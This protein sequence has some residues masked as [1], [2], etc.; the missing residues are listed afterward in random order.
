MSFWVTFALNC[1]E[2]EQ[3][4]SVVFARVPQK[5]IHSSVRV[6]EGGLA[7]TYLD[8]LAGQLRGSP[9]KTFTPLCGAEREG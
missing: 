1:T 6:R 7:K 3:R 2:V 8:L 9:K 5:D 4:V